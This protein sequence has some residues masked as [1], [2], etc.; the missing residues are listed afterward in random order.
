L[1]VT[2]YPTAPRPTRIALFQFHSDIELCRSRI[3]LL[4]RF[5]PGLRIFGLYGGPTDMLRD[6]RALE[7]YGIEHVHHDPRHLPAWNKKNTDLAVAGWYRDVG[8]SISF[9]RL[10]V[11]QWDLLFFAPLDRVYPIMPKDAVALSGLI[12]L[13][14]VSHVWAWTVD[15]PLAGESAT[16]VA[17][18]REQFGD[19]VAFYA[20]LGPGYSLSSVFLDRYARLDVDDV[21]HDEL[22]LPVFAQI[23][24]VDVA[25]TGFYP[26]WVDADVERTFNADAA[27]IDPSVV[28]SELAQPCGR[29]VFHPCRHRFDAVVVQD[30]LTQLPAHA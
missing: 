10:D 7:A 29:R 20:C 17:R 12:P 2:D 23:V 13:T 15:E 24:G 18:V 6:A 4:E 28:A 25:D 30:L 9:D 1:S 5:N 11:V 19:R 26:R 3:T 14:D 8:R 21:G 16:F 27:E 22:R